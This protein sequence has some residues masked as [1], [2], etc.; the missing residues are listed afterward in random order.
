MSCFIWFPISRS[1][2]HDMLSEGSP[3]IFAL[4]TCV[5]E[6]YK[7]TAMPTGS[8]TETPKDCLYLKTKFNEETE[9]YESYDVFNGNY[10]F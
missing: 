8:P 1:T 6:S 7:P 10:R 3:E 5:S 9:E 4:L 2:V